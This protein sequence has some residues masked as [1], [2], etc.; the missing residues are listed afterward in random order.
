MNR[1]EQTMKRS[2]VL[3]AALAAAAAVTLVGSSSGLAS[4]YPDGCEPPA[5]STSAPDSGL[6]QVARTPGGVHVR[7]YAIDP[8]TTGPID[9]KVL[10]DDVETGTVT[11]DDFYV[12]NVLRL[13]F[14][15]HGDYH[16][17]DD[18]A[19]ARA[20]SR[21]CIEPVDFDEKGAPAD[22][23]LAGTASC[24]GFAVGV[25]PVGALESLARDNSFVR[26]RGWALDP[27]RAEGARVQVYQDGGLEATAAATLSRPEIVPPGHTGYGVRH[28]FDVPVPKGAA[29]ASAGAL[30]SRAPTWR[31]TPSTASACGR[32]TRSAT[33]T[34]RRSREHES[35]RRRRRS[36]ASASRPDPS[37]SATRSTTPSRGA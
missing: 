12:S 15:R 37:S 24:M 26:V 19:P 10:I 13:V 27:D 20:G 17:V 29:R 4:C 34:R 32:G 23:P 3:L 22:P 11:A 36:S 35:P 2:I 8:D 33:P 5:A 21:V 31:L 7:G 14:P 25:D 1:K 30:P 28:G 6:H 16:G 18:V 9:A